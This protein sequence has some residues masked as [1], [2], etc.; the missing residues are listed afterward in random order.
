MVESYHIALASYILLSPTTMYAQ[1]ACY[2]YLIMIMI[3]MQG[4]DNACK[5]DAVSLFAS[6]IKIHGR[7][8]LRIRRLH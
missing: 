3:K 6:V 1:S 8:V 7:I 4:K 5:P 2:H